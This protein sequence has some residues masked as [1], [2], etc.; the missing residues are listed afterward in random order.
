MKKSG[1]RFGGIGYFGAV[2]SRAGSIRHLS[3]MDSRIKKMV[4]RL[5]KSD[6]IVGED[7]QSGEDSENHAF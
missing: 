3:E 6:L 1:D 2:F 7:S 5:K 4:K